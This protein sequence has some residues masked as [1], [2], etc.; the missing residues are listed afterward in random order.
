VGYWTEL[1]LILQAHTVWDC[2]R[3]VDA[4]GLFMQCTKLLV[5]HGPVVVFVSVRC[6]QC[7]FELHKV[8]F[9]LSAQNMSDFFG[10]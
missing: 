7:A 10:Q 3:T 9:A 1:C 4:T 5:L 2:L 6:S 8:V